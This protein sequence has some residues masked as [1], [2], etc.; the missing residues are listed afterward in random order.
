MCG[1]VGIWNQPNEEIVAKMARSVEHR[2]PDGLHWFTK[3]NNSF[4]ASRLTIVGDPRGSA[5]FNDRENNTTILLNGEIYNIAILRGEL[6]QN[7]YTFR[8]DLESE[9]VVKL[10]IHY[11]TDFVKHLKGMFAIAII[12]GD[13]LVLARDRF[14]IK[15][16]YYTG[17]SDV[18]LFGSEIKAILQHPEARAN[19][20]A[21]AFEEIVV[22]GY[23]YS[24]D[25]TLFE[26]IH[27]VEP[28]QIIIFSKSGQS[29]TK[30]WQPLAASYFDRE[31]HP[32]FSTALLQMRQTIIDNVDLVFKHGDHPK[33]VYLSG[34]LDSSILTLVIRSILGYPVTTFTMA[35]S[36]EN[37][38][39]IAARQVAQK[40]GTRHIERIVTV[41]DY[42]HRLEHFVRHYE[43]IVA[44]GVYDIH[45]GMAFHLLSETVSDHVKVAFSGE[46]ADELFGGYYWVYTHPLGFADRIRN[47]L[48]PNGGVS[49]IHKLVEQLFPLPENELIYRR[50]LFDALIQGGLANY[51][52]QSVD[53]SAG[54]FGFEIRP[55][56]LFDDLA[57]FALDLP[58]DYKVPDKRITK[59]ILREA[60]RPE[61][62]KLGLGW[63]STRLKEGMPA[64]VSNIAP[65]VTQR[66]EDSIS[67]ESLAKHPMRAYLQSKTDMYLFD[68]FAKIFLTEA[69]YAVQ[70]CIPQQVSSN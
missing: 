53:R 4:G 3:G 24:P 59:W 44:G 54:A 25:R 61:L 23:V 31:R 10:Y 15:P 29:K 56:Y 11:G 46:G 45:G 51:H 13:R 5:I 48:R 16:L 60:F 21:Q 55:A 2:G 36:H 69:G 8:T 7:G 38:D 19:L 33:G 37:T 34:G 43:S 35:D 58:I 6:A 28:G 63:V 14:G 41:D 32:D 50:N 12:D 62:E 42:F 64:S 39:F 68:V 57:T 20:D 26:G 22:F 40:L 52:L 65:L 18:V 67:N 27:Q 49:E 47:R 30:Y 1:I 70:D 66:I 9:V 17:I